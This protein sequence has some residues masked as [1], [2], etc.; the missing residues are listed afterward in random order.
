[1]AAGAALWLGWS[2]GPAGLAR[3]LVGEAPARD[4]LL[5]V[6]VGLVV[7]AASRWATPRFGWSRRLARA[8]ARAL[9]PLPLATCAVVAAFSAVGEELLFRG[10]LQP[11]LGW[12]PATAL[13]AAAHVPTERDLAP[14]PLFA[15]GAGLLLAGLFELTSALLAPVAC[16]FV[17][18]LLN[19]R[20]LGAPALQEERDRDR[21][22]GFFQ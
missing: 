10:V 13:F 7:V 3:R 6:T 9:G 14:W 20:A 19:L 8:M 2:L 15:L 17:V 12:L 18:N 21:D 5:G 16:H 22:D 4:L 11:W 1:M